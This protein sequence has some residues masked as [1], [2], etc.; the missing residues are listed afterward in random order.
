MVRLTFA[1]FSARPELLVAISRRRDG[2][3]T[4]GGERT[5]RQE[6]QQNRE[7]FLRGF[8]VHPERVVYARPV[9]GNRIV[10]V[11]AK[12]RGK[13]I[14]DT[15]GL[16][17][18]TPRTFLAVTV[19]DGLPIFFYDQKRRAIGIAHAGWRSL[20]AGILP[21]A[22][23]R[24]GEAFRTPPERLL[25]GIGPGIGLCHF[26]VGPEVV[27]KFS[28]YGPAM[29]R[30]GS[31]TY[32]DLKAVAVAQLKTAGVRP[33]HVEV[34]PDCTACLPGEYFSCRRDRPA[35]VEA[36]LAVIGLIA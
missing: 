23:A 5:R 16:L 3:M 19:A 4:T 30:R 9:H 32:L 18:A 2:T 6:G 26:A 15:D 8:G 17:T 14:A 10:V 22:V 11:S 13:V 27:A 36:M 1:S 31:A 28:A 29:A 7:R 25:A 20:V 33:T 21:N 34:H 24:M 12:D 35:A